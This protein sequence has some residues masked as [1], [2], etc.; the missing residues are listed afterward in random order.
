[1]ADLSSPQPSLAVGQCVFVSINKPVPLGHCKLSLPRSSKC[2]QPRRGGSNLLSSCGWIT[3]GCQQ[4]SSH[5]SPFPHLILPTSTH[6]WRCLLNVVSRH[7]GGR[8]IDLSLWSLAMK[9]KLQSDGLLQG[10]YSS[11]LT[12]S[13]QSHQLQHAVPK[14]LLPACMQKHFLIKSEQSKTLLLGR[15]LARS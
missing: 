12:L 5:T 2:W 6:H 10:F 8:R 9:P 3:G 15:I 11:S 4:G 13:G 14:G 1:M 7:T